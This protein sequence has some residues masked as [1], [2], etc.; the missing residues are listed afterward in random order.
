MSESENPLQI[1]TPIE[2]NS[3]YQSSFIS[4]VALLLAFFIALPKTPSTLHSL[5]PDQQFSLKTTV[6]LRAT[7]PL[8]RSEKFRSK[9][10]QSKLAPAFSLA[11]FHPLSAT[12]TISSN[13]HSKN[14]IPSSWSRRFARLVFRQIPATSKPKLYFVITAEGD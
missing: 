6:I 4:I 14:T 1:A 9:Y 7:I 2:T 13:K 11:N 3:N 12:I 5:K 8:R 10:I